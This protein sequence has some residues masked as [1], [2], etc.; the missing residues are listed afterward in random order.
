MQSVLTKY[1]SIPY[2]LLVWRGQ[3]RASHGVEMHVVRFSLVFTVR[4]R[5]GA[6]QQSPKEKRFCYT[7]RFSLWKTS[8]CSAVMFIT[9]SH[10]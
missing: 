9:A 7:V 3:I 2:H 8:R 5:C 4:T 10:K 6:V 1:V